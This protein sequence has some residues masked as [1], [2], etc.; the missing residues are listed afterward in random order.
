MSP[1]GEANAFQSLVEALSDLHAEPV[2]R[3]VPSDFIVLTINSV[4][5]SPGLG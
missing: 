2:N 3:T 4:G 5:F 1:D